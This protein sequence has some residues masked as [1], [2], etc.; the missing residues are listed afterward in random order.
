MKTTRRQFLVTTGVA[1]AVSALGVPAFAQRKNVNSKLNVACI[2]VGGQ[3]AASVD[4]VKGENIVALCDAFEP[5]LKRQMEQYPNAKGFADFREMYDQIGDTID[6]VTVGTPDHT[7]AVASLIG[8]NKGI[9]CYCEKP[10]CHNTSEVARMMAVAKEKKLVTQMGTQ[11]HAEPNY[12]RVV[13]LVQSGA[14]G[15]IT[16]VHVWCGKDWG[17]Q[18]LPTDTP[19][20]PDGLNW[21]LWLGPAQERPYHPCYVP[22]GWRRWWAFGT[23]TLGDMA[24]HVMDLPY[25]ALNLKYPT[26][27]EAV[28]DEQPDPEG[29]PGSLS[30]K[31]IYATPENQALPVT[32]YDGN[33]RPEVIKEIPGEPWMG[34]LFVGTEGKI[35][36]D[37]GRCQ[38]LPEEKFKEFKR[39][40]ASIPNSIGH[41]REWIK[42]IYDNKPENCLCQFDYSGP[43]SIAVLLGT[44]AF[45]TGK[46]LE[47]DAQK[48]SVSNAP[49]ALPYLTREYRKGWEIG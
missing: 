14:I 49:E 1:A 45:R 24:C 36:A 8:M 11:I 20:V 43:M 40:A 16:E 27:I 2:G 13:E 35:F 3:G 44:V 19:P 18:K 41:Y 42:A 7:H 17:G 33:L 25:W 29:A 10:L 15:K 4:G 48:M 23:G 9:H 37:Y 22:G 26:R 28:C 30:I 32:W 47:W 38:L 46:T 34:V 39:P 31:Y 12:R 5:N 21:D 6:A